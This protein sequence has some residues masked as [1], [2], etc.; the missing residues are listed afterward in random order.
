MLSRIPS[1]KTIHEPVDV[2]D[3]LRLQL[4]NLF[5]IHAK[6]SMKKNANRFAKFTSS[7]NINL[8]Q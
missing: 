8:A 6:A 2:L 7:R 5:G 3:Q 4:A 1:K